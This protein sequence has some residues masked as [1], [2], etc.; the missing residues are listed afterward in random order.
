MSTAGLKNDQEK[1]RMDLVPAGAT[2]EIAKV[3]TFGAK[4]YAEHN[5]RNG[6]KYSRLIAAL[7]RHIAA[8]KEN[9]DMD[10]ESGLYHMGHAG[11]C[12][13]M[14]L[15]H[16]LKGYGE[17]DRYKPVVKDTKYA[18]KNKMYLDKSR[19]D[20]TFYIGDILYKSYYDINCN[21]IYA[22]PFDSRL[23]NYTFDQKE[24]RYCGKGLYS[25]IPDNSS[26]VE[27]FPTWRESV[28]RNETNV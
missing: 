16:Q 22:L 20:E 24:F 12:V 4:K 19:L 13:M 8:F 28:E 2:T 27:I 14:L 23:E 26:F 10:P 15:E 5:W 1:P 6:F 25:G 11:C 21:M 17:D 7:E 9:E 3:F 18:L